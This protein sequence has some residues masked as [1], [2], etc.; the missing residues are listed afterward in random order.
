MSQNAP[1]TAG[2]GREAHIRKTMV[3]RLTRAI[4]QSLTGRTGPA[5]EA[6]QGGRQ[7]AREAQDVIAKGLFD[8]DFY[9]MAYPDVDAD[10]VAA[11]MAYLDTGWTKGHFPRAMIGLPKDGA[12]D[13]KA[14]EY[15]DFMA[16]KRRLTRIIEESALFSEGWYARQYPE[17]KAFQMSPLAHYVFLGSEM[18]LAP[19][20]LFDPATYLKKVRGQGVRTGDLFA[21]YIRRLQG[22]SLMTKVEAEP[23]LPPEPAFPE[24][25]IRPLPPLTR[26]P[27]HYGR[28]FSDKIAQ[29][30]ELRADDAMTPDHE[31][32]RRNFDFAFYMGQHYDMAAAAPSLDLV[33][34]YLRTERKERRDP[35][36]HFSTKGLLKRHPEVLKQN[37]SP[38][39]YWLKKGR[40][41]GMVALPPE[42]TE[43]VAGL[44]GH[45]DLAE[46]Q[47]RLIAWRSDV[48]D[49]LD[50]G[51]LGE[52]VAKAAGFD[53]LINKVWKKAFA[54]NLQPVTNTRRLK[55]LTAMSQLFDAAGRKRADV[56]IAVNAPRW[57]GGPR[58]E[59]FI[60]KAV[61]DLDLAG[62]LV[63][64]NT[65]RSGEI[66]GFRCP[67]GSRSIDFA[68]AVEGLP[69]ADRSR[70]LFEFLRAL[71]PRTIFNVNSKS[72][73]S[74]LKRYQ[75]QCAVDLPVVG[76]F[77]CD[78]I[79]VYGQFGGYPSTEFYRHFDA[80]KAVCT[81]SAYL[82]DRFVDQYMVPQNQQHK[83]EVL[84]APVD[85]SLP[86]YLKPPA[87]T[88]QRPE[89]F[90]SSRWD[91]QK[92]IPLLLEIAENMPDVAFRV[93]GAPVAQT[94][95]TVFDNAPENISIEG[96][97]AV[98][99]SIPLNK[100][101][102][103]LYTSDWDGVPSMLLEVGMTGIPI[104]GSNVGGCPEVL[105]S[106]HAW[107]IHE[108]EGAD[109]Y[110]TALRF[111]LD[112]PGVARAR[113]AGLRDRLLKL[114]TATA[115]RDKVA[116]LLSLEQVTQMELSA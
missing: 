75:R 114:R 50:S 113:A 51:V 58:M 5:A 80:M 102:A 81:D 47:E 71:H 22:I 68:S 100:A 89:V 20:P 32:V 116:G 115:Y 111:I 33:A 98:F 35:S 36:A 73:W 66:P 85:P 10:P 74:M 78:D 4:G 37:V 30:R 92:R 49:R 76:C 95:R 25:D 3:L 12:L 65:E 40:T 23:V 55:M 54:P 29:V 56:V 79:N 70:V 27:G 39:V 41:E 8:P 63:L 108:D 17:V 64:I 67:P 2:P 31:L 88:Q 94:G 105:H 96:E 48:R 16:Q 7:L 44:L 84:S 21:H 112:N 26:Q 57:G 61:A 99:T 87:A 28:R 19:T 83:I 106:S 13:A 72:V 1:P 42:V 6:K 11:A 97:Y 15:I 52:M 24:D 91:V 60:A 103:W 110:V 9:R 38:F 90:W 107:P 53:P 82:A 18:S 93:W 43:Q 46:T 101:S 104:V 62:E 109:A 69:E 34:H 77:F 59:G 86:A 14:P 45:S